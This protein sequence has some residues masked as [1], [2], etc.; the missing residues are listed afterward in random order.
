[1]GSFVGYAPI[2]DPQFAVLVKVYN[3]KEV[4]WAESTAAPAFGEIMKFLLEY[5]KV[6]PTEEYE[7]K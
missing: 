5:Y 1:M 6:K 3:P 7:L 4:Q 2:D